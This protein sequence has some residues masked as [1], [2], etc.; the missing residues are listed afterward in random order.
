[1]QASK[2]QRGA[3]LKSMVR[4]CMPRFLIGKLHHKTMSTPFHKAVGELGAIL[5]TWLT[6]SAPRQAD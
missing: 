5:K 4:W 1:M 2:A 6:F 3:H